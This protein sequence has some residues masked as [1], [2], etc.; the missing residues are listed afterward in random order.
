MITGASLISL[1][2]AH[3]ILVLLL[4]MQICNATAGHTYP[5]GDVRV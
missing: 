4:L 2:A 1:A 5:D 3:D